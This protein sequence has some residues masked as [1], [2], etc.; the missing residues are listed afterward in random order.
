MDRMREQREQLLL[1]RA[2][3]SICTADLRG[4]TMQCP[5]CSG[6]GLKLYAVPVVSQVGSWPIA[7]ACYFCYLRI[8]KN[9]PRP[10]DIVP[11]SESGSRT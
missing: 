1:K 11:G 9:A 5:M 10:A 3:G 7:T 4:G 8:T 2:A 6:E